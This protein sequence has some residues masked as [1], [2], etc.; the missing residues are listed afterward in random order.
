MNSTLVEQH[1]REWMETDDK[2]SKD[3][4]VDQGYRK[5]VMRK[6]IFM[7]V[8]IV[9]AFI[10]VGLALT[11]GTYKITFLETY[12]VIWEHITGNVT[13]QVADEVIFELGKLGVK[14]A[15]VEGYDTAS[16]ILIDFL[17]VVVHIFQQS[18]REFYNLEKLWSGTAA[19]KRKNE[20]ENQES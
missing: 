18:E 12:S 2:S 4:A 13:D 5:Y 6:W 1:I 20:Q 16:W 9:A 14:P 10:T 17:D 15:G 7:A 8:C 3:E 11:I 19:A